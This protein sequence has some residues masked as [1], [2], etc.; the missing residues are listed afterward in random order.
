[1]VVAGVLDKTTIE[2]NATNVAQ[3]N[4][5]FTISTPCCRVVVLDLP[6]TCGRYQIQIPLLLER[7]TS[8]RVDILTRSAVGGKGQ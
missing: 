1:M 8:M 4:E 3:R 6:V 7:L 5:A 2:T